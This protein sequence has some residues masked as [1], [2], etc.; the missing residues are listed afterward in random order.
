MFQRP[1]PPFRADHVGSLLRPSILKEAREN[2]TR[3]KISLEAL[4]VIEDREIENIIRKQENIGL[5]A[6]TDGEFRRSWWH[7]D[8]LWG[9]DGVAKL[10]L[11]TGVTFADTQTRAEGTHVFGKLGYSGHPMLDHFKFVEAYTERVPKMSIPAPSAI[12]GRPVPLAIESAVYPDREQFFYDLGT[13]YKEAVQDF[14][15]AG[16]RYLQFDEVFIAM[17]CDSK[18]RYQMVERGDDP[19]RLA[20]IYGDLINTAISDIPS[21][22]SITMHLCRGNYKSTFMGSGSY[23]AVQDVLFN[24]INVDGY[25]LEYDD[26]RSGGFEPLRLLPKNKVV[27]LGLV[28]TKTGALES[29]DVIKRRVEQAAK[30]VDIDQLCLS[31]QCGFASTEEGNLLSEDDQWAKLALI[32]EVANEIW[33]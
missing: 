27:V 14:A 25:F 3:D 5:E 28:T 11:G 26:E 10:D 9:L 20:E 17:L 8:F 16:C 13:V 12:Y 2:Y 19:E 31:G 30:F 6:V 32:V 7:L 21:D 23:D 22:L 15:N 24:K 1:K 4:K 18:Y 33:S 29:K